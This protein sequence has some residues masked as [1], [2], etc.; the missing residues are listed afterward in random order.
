MA[1]CKHELKDLVG[2]ADGIHCTKCGAVFVELPLNKPE[3]KP[4][5]AEKPAVKEAPK[6]KGAK[7]A[8]K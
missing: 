7:N 3:S 6:K 5:P 1:E 2:M 4:E 8:R